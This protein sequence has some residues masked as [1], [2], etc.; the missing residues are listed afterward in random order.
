VAADNPF[1]YFDR[2]Y[3]VSLPNAA[4]REALRVQLASVGIA[5]ALCVH[6]KLPPYGFT[7][8]NMERRGSVGN[9]GANLSHVK[10]IVHAIADGAQRPLFL[11]DDVVFLP[12]AAERLTAALAVLPPFWDV[13][14]MG[15]HPRG[16][17][18]RMGPIVKVG[19]F[20]FAESYAMSRKALL[21][22]FDSWCDRITQ[23]DAMYDFLLGKFAAAN[24]GYCVYP[25]LTEQPPGISQISGK[26]DDKRG[27]VKR[28]WQANC[29]T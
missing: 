1:A 10:A 23:P 16:P 19:E 20:S 14:Y 7:M 25:L 6:A 24:N 2:V 21:A 17:V 18:T 28:G 26:A 22:F 13:L 15:G 12:G 3:A 27:L 8:S 5:D 11:E 9:M 29:Q 4:R